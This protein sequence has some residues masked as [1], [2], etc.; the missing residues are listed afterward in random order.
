MWAIFDTLT[1][2]DEYIRRPE[3]SKRTCDEYT[4]LV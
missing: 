2:E 4:R 1:T 3:F